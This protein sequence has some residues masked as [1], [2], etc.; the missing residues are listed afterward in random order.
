MPTS[1]PRTA[2]WRGFRA[3]LPFSLMVVPFGTIF[4][5]IAIEAGLNLV[6]AMS[7]TVL[8]IAGAS[9][10]TALQ[11]MMDNAPVWVV[12][13]SALAVNLRMAMYSAALAPHLGP[14]PFWTRATAAYLLFDQTYALSGLEYETRP[15]NS[16]AAKVAFYFGSA[17]PILPLWLISS[18]AG[19]V[20]GSAI[21]EEFGLEFAVPIMF[22]AIIG[23]ALRTPAHIAAAFTAIV[24]ALSLAFLP[25][26]LWLIVAGLGGMM[27]GAEVERRTALWKARRV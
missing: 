13:L 9:Q 6:E 7:M 25:W 12:V 8:V 3:A 4:G 27:I 16:T 14:A 26:N 2:Y 24:L 11:L 10:L 5:V 21:P 22:L 23:P 19:A 20:L 17:S 15:A 1:T 18:Y